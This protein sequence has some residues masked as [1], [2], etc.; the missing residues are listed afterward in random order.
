MTDLTKAMFEHSL[1]R[2]M[3]PWHDKEHDDL[4]PEGATVFEAVDHWLACRGDIAPVG[5][6]QTRWALS[7]QDVR[8]LA[9]HIE[10]WLAR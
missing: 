4:K 5:L 2:S 1:A 6:G 10:K 8:H 9:E 7:D 3:C